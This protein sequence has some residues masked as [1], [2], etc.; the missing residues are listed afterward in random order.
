MKLNNK[1][2]VMMVAGVVVAMV[3][4]VMYRNMMTARA[5]AANQGA[6][7]V[8]GT[9]WCMYTKK[10]RDHLDTKYG[11]GS[12][13]YV[14]CDNEQCDGIDAFPVTKTPNG[15]MVKGFNVDI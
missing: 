15:D 6:F 9:D 12:H 7:T 1:R 11:N 13:T 8:Y 2:M 4:V 10:Q 5:P 14:N 3:A